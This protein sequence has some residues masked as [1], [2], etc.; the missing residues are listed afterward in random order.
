MSR[1]PVV[2][3]DFYPTLLE[4]CN[5]P[6][7]PEQHV[8]GRSIVRLL[9]GGELAERPIFWHYP[10][11]GNQGGEPSSIITENDWKLIHFHEDGRD[12]LY[13]LA[14]DP[15]EQTDL[16]PLEPGRVKALRA[17]LH[18]WLKDTG[19]IFP[20][21]DTQF[22]AAKREA[23]W[24]SLRTHGKARLEKQHASY[25]EATYTANS[26]WWGSVPRE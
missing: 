25:L 16:A 15:S 3:T 13:Q 12:E 4:L 2:S 10:H 20:T 22:N 9:K 23:R 11:Y 5:L 6:P 1:E 8:D 26:D 17:K 7:R 14:T 18:A 21:K 19:A 24:E